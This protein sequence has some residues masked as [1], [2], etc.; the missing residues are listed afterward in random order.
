MILLTV[1]ERVVSAITETQGAD[2][3]DTIIEYNARRMLESDEGPRMYRATQRP[4]L[5]EPTPEETRAIME[6]L[7]DFDAPPAVEEAIERHRDHIEE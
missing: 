1:V 2:S 3:D 7:N 6:Q 4:H 5:R